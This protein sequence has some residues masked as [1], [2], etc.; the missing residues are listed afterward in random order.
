MMAFAVQGRARGQC[1]DH[2]V[3]AGE[4]DVDPDDLH[5]A[6]PEIGAIEHFH[7]DSTVLNMKAPHCAAL[8][9]KSGGSV[10]REAHLASS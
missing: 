5:Q 9:F 10:G 6:D 4:D 8:S 2:G 7:V 1:D 3:V